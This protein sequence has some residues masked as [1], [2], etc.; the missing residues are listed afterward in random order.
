MAIS[1]NASTVDGRYTLFLSSEHCRLGVRNAWYLNYVAPIGSSQKLP[2]ALRKYF[3]GNG[4]STWIILRHGFRAW[5]VE[6]VNFEFHEGWDAFREVHHLNTEFKVT[7]S[8]ERKW[9]FHTALFDENDCELVFKWSAPN[10]QWQ[11]F[12]P[13]PANLRTT[14]LTSLVA[15]HQTMLKFGFWCLPGQELHLECEAR[16]NEV[17]E[18]FDLED[19]V[20]HM[21]N[22]AWE[23]AIQNLKLDVDEFSEF[24]NA[25]KMELL[26]YILIIMLPTAEFYVI[27]FDTSNE[28]EKVYSW[29]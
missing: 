24:W 7:M 4:A 29:F 14:C 21:G 17:F 10:L 19:M 15:K 25:L 12:H 16:L 11:D 3:P 13:P 28:A 1:C 26:D 18:V 5:P 20:I 22:R 2:I 6:V 23:V 8:Y 27:V 9:I